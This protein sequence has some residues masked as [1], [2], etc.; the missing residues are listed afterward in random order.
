MFRPIDHDGEDPDARAPNPSTTF[1][2]RQALQAGDLAKARDQ[3]EE[4]GGA[5]DRARQ[6]IYLP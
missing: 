2:L 4:M 1:G 6:A 5:M 3:A